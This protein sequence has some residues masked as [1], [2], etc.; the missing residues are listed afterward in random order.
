MRQ[1]RQKEY[2]LQA[3]L[4]ALGVA[5]AFFIPF[6]IKDRGYFLFYGD[7]NVQQVPFYQMNHAM[8]RSGDIFWNWYTDL[9]VNF[10]GSYS[11]YTLGS[12][13]FWLT[14]PFPNEIVP[15][16]M[17]PLLILKFACASLTAYAFIRRFVKNPSS[18]LIGGLLYAFCGFSVYN[19]FFNHFHEAIVFF[20]LVLL[21]LELYMAENVKG[22]FAF[23]L[24][25]SAMANYFFFVGMGVFVLIYWFLR[26]LSGAWRMSMP[27]F[28]WLA[29]EVTVGISIAGILL[30]PSYFAVIQNPRTDY[31]YY[32]YN[33]FLYTKPQ[34]YANIIEVFF[35]PPDLPARP[36][37]FPGTEERWASLAAWMPLF[38]MTGVLAYLT[39]KK[40]T[41]LR[42]IIILLAFMA[43]IP[44][45]NSAFILFNSSYYARWF[46]MPVLMMA[47]ATAV[48][49]ED[50]EVNWKSGLRW[51]AFIV[52]AFTLAVGLYPVQGGGIEQLK[53]IRFPSME[54]YNKF[55]EFFGL[56][57]KEF[58][59]RFWITCAISIISLVI[60]GVLIPLMRKSPKTFVQF[61]VIGIVCISIIYSTYFIG[62]GKTHSYDT[63]GHVI[64]DLIQGEVD[65][66][67]DSENFRI[68]V[69]EGMDNTGMFF[70][71]PTIQA[72][73][74]IVPVSVMDFYNYI[75]VERTVGSRPE[76][77][78]YGIRPLLSVKYLL[79][80]TG[81]SKPF[82]ENNEPK[83]E[84][85]TFYKHENNYDIYENENYLPMGFT[86]EY[87][88]NRE[89]CETHG[90]S[91]RELMMLKAIL[92]E[93][94]QIKKY[95]DILKPLD[96]TTDPDYY[97]FYTENRYQYYDT[98]F[99]EG[100]N[101]P[102]QVNFSDEDFTEDCAAR[103]RE[104]AHSFKRDTHGFTAK[105]N[106]EK[107][108]LVFFSVPYEDGWSAKVNGKKVEIEKVNVGF[109]AVP[110]PAGENIEIRFDYETPGLKLG[111]I[112]SLG[113]VIL[114]LLYI[115]G[116]KLYK[117]NHTEEFDRLPLPAA[118]NE[119]EEIPG[120]PGIT[121]SQSL[122]SALENLSVQPE[123]DSE[124]SPTAGTLFEIQS[125][126]GQ[127][128][129]D[130]AAKPDVWKI[131]EPPQGPGFQVRIADPADYPSIPEDSVS[132]EAPTSEE[133]DSQNP[134]AE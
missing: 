116:W 91:Y 6:I 89:S 15:Y 44:T 111:I 134:S 108:N 19:V 100:T 18:A 20:P 129:D 58:D 42:R 45:L 70:G 59:D 105:I 7:F 67:D 121:D 119:F 47:L 77:S 64:P 22:I 123:E 96:E 117:R 93:D 114:L 57:V 85:Y 50:P 23:I 1:L 128:E 30:V 56:Y 125:E 127:P 51:N 39:S 103:R 120:A 87:Y 10:I 132:A 43:L 92:L 115:F 3:F 133:D 12:P 72:F 8:L 112:V 27:R 33:A 73:H 109:M 131:P 53:S 61:S 95:R 97:K 34:L 110:A 49:I 65:L 90:Q 75:D 80:Y 86:Y 55:I 71:Y 32:G 46:Y 84:G 63:T 98:E 9:G 69:Y 94:D 78:H 83:M 104:S 25:L 107:E 14:L 4:L 68:D 29:F 124:Q 82:V 81:D 16:F 74:S 52:A 118:G 113:S 38:G 60:I 13:F 24:F 2:Y 36:V 21:A 130:T 17:G 37:F 122:Q 66:E 62:M 99:P 31:T 5:F 48:S 11:F 76:V 26:I 126:P 79:D 102:V 101:I 28:F 40:G 54:W 88:I 106:L 41:W 35:F